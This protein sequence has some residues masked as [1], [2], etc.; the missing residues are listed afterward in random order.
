MSK[1]Q[2]YHFSRSCCV[3]EIIH[4]SFCPPFLFQTIDEESLKKLND[5]QLMRLLEEAYN[6]KKKDEKITRASFNVRKKCFLSLLPVLDF[7]HS[8]EKLIF[9]WKKIPFQKIIRN[10]LFEF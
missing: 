7:Y 5:E 9:M 8:A 2:P 3:L 4:Y 1:L 6:S 10:Y